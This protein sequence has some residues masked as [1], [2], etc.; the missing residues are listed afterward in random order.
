MRPYRFRAMWVLLSTLAAC[1]PRAT[2]Y[3]TVIRHGTVY[4]GSGGPPIQADVAISG[5]SIVAVGAGLRGKAAREIDA[6]GLAVA[7]GFINMLSWAT[8]SLIEDGRSQ[9]D[10]Q[11]GVTLEVMGEG[12]SM[13]PVTDTLRK[14]MLS[15][16]GDITYP[17][18]WTSLRG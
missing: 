11:Q 4:D 16:Q 12:N 9:S 18:T 2:V 17:I 14:I 8:E 15:Q 10:I 1:A 3:D 5:D 6:Q 13:G 7:P